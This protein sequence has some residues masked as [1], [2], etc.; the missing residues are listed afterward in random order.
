MLSYDQDTLESLWN[1]VTKEASAIADD[2]KEIAKALFSMVNGDLDA[3]QAYGIA[4]RGVIDMISN[5]LKLIL[6][7]L[8]K[9][10]SVSL[11]AIEDI[12]RYS[13]DIPIFFL[14]RYGKPSLVGATSQ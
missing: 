1:D 5:S 10:V 12:G 7:I 3:P 4:T 9:G 6:D 11:Q 2:V 8:L 14:L 13:A